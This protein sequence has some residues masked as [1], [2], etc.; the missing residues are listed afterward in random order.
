[1]SHM[2]PDFDFAS[3]TSLDNDE[4]LQRHAALDEVLHV[5]R[6]ETTA[7]KAQSYFEAA[8][9]EILTRA[10]NGKLRFARNPSRHLAG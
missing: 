4:L 9:G 10:V 3:F 5:L 6:G 8:E 2:T 1:M 7:V